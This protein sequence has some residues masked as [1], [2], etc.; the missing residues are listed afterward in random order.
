[1]IVLFVQL[2][3]I[4][5]RIVLIFVEVVVLNVIIRGTVHS[6]SLASFGKIQLVK[7][8]IKNAIFVI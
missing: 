6:V 4:M 1:M 3:L 7:I 5:L 2:V 8:A